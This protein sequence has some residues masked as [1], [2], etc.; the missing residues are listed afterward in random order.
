MRNGAQVRI[1]K[2]V[3]RKSKQTRENGIIFLRLL[4]DA[5]RRAK[6]A[7]LLAMAG[8]LAFTTVLS[9]VPLLAV[10]F[11]VFKIFGG[12]D[13]AYSKL[14]PFLLDI[15]SE[16]TG[17][18][19]AKNLNMFIQ[20]V[21]TQAIGA[22]GI[23]GLLFTWVV[24]Y[25]TVVAA[26]NRIW[27]VEHPKSFQHR[28]I[29]AII[30]LTVGPVILGASIVLTTAIATEI[31][32]VPHSA[33]LMSFLLTTILF[34][35]VYTLVPMAKI[36]FKTILVGSLLPALLLECAK[37]AYAIYTRKMVSY[38]AF[39]GSFAAIPLFLL[40]IYIAWT[41]TLFGAVWIRTLQLYKRNR[42]G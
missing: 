36:S 38:S 37:F 42:Y 2:F 20:H 19:V 34:T 35:M 22:V 6:K 18:V 10:A 1:G 31:Q 39:Y 24:T 23:A 8:S 14:M 33:T 9:I 16:G 25:Q 15:L 12:F 7:D 11:Y 5:L 29:R 21:H 4:V 13:Y 41:I 17:E 26:F 3:R 40:W 30:L 28:L 27:E 32:A